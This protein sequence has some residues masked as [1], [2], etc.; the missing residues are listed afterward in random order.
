MKKTLLFILLFLPLVF[1][2][3]NT[4]FGIPQYLVKGDTTF[5]IATHWWVNHY[6]DSLRLIN[7]DDTVSNVATKHDILQ[8]VDNNKWLVEGTKQSSLVDTVVTTALRTDLLKV[9]NYNVSV[10]GNVSIPQSVPTYTATSPVQVVSTVVSIKPDTLTSWYTKQNQGAAVYS[11]FPKSVLTLRNDDSKANQ[12]SW[13]GAAGYYGNEDGIPETAFNIYGNSD[14]PL[15]HISNDKGKVYGSGIE[16]YNFN[17]GEYL[18]DDAG[19]LGYIDFSAPSYSDSDPGFVKNIGGSIVCSS[20]GSWKDVIDGHADWGFGN[21][22][23]KLRYGNSVQERMRITSLGY[24]G[25]G[26][27]NPGT[28]LD[29]N[30]VITATGGTSTSWNAKVSS[31][32]STYGSNIGFTGGNVGIGSTAPAN[33]LDIG[34]P[35]AGGNAKIYSTLG[36]E[37]AP[38]LTTGNWTLGTGWTYGTSPD[39]IEKLIDGTGTV[40]P[41]AATTIVAGTKYRVVIVIGSLSGSTATYTLGGSSGT[42]LAAATTYTDD[43]VA[44][45]TGKLIVTPVATGLRMV[46]SSISIKAMTTGN[47][48]VSGDLLA[49]TIKSSTGVAAMTVAPNGNIGIKNNNPITELYI[50]GNVMSTGYIST[51]NGNLSL[52]TTELNTS[53]AAVW[54]IKNSSTN[55]ASAMSFWTKNIEAIRINPAQQV[56]IGTTAPNTKLHVYGSSR[57]GGVST[58]SAKFTAGLVYM[59]NLPAQDTATKIIGYNVGTGQLKAMTYIHGIA[60]ADSMVASGNNYITI[61]GT[62][63]VYYKIN[64]SGASPGAMAAREQD[65]V[66]IQGDSCKILTAGDYKVHIWISATTGTANDKIKVKLFTNNTQNATTLGRFIIN[67]NNS[68]TTGTTYFMWYKSFAVNDWISF[69]ATNLSASRTILISDVKYL[70]EKVYE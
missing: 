25:I 51:N 15:M 29:V 44:A 4:R 53:T 46:I 62:Q 1:V 64:T 26:K 10:T 30:G 43:V 34:T 6:Y 40:T 19:E 54:P 48:T 37:L 8:V 18:T 61:G 28:T 69:R 56:G 38:A 7:W 59:P 23:F 12:F 45:T 66:L 68:T 47:L 24:V 5:T 58:D 31:Q 16:L 20:D 52:Y 60:S 63:N 2:G 67:S 50:N 14:I 39:R 27:T 36:T 70:I 11:W 65:G 55:A 42:A 32:W 22:K 57:F 21:F 9:G 17:S 35:A 13:V 3:Q 33:M 49:S 41:T